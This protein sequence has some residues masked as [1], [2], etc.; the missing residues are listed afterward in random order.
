MSVEK[1][2]RENGEA[3]EIEQMEETEET[4]MEDTKEMKTEETDD[5]LETDS[6]QF[7]T[8]SR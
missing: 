6:P 5:G 8:P 3:M 7:Y 1:I 4:K 2:W